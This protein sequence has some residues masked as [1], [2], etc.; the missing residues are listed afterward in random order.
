[1][2][3]QL[4]DGQK[5]AKD[6]YIALQLA[7][8][9]LDFQPGIATI[10]TEDNA[11]S[12]LYASKRG[13]IA[14]S[15]GMYSEVHDLGGS[16][17]D[18]DI[19]RLISNLNKDVKIHGIIVQMPLPKNADISAVL[20]SLNPKKDADGMHPSNLGN[21]FLGTPLIIPAASKSI[22]ELINST[23]ISLPGTKLTV[24]GSGLASGKPTAILLQN[25]GAVVTVCNSKTKNL[26][27]HTLDADIV[28]ASV[29][30]VKILTEDMIKEGAIVIDAG[31]NIVD[32]KI[33][34]DVDFEA[35][36]KK[37]AYITQVPGGLG[38]LTSAS[39]LENVIFLATH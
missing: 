36:S 31:I 15:I 24:I 20:G 17:K 30:K 29:G 12:K 27:S 9:K 1:M 16:S 11:A 28:I 35:V 5:I 23:G 4:I 26:K 7:I 21:L 2:P 33:I 25:K 22:L 37:A 18:E 8:A 3:A 14:K 34:G 38:P 39:L 19:I 32:G 6:K 10:V 13:E